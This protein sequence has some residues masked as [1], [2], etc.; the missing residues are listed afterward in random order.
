MVLI[1]SIATAQ[2]L[3][4]RKSLAKKKNKVKKQKNIRTKKTP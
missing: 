4:K 1:K 3:K 2:L